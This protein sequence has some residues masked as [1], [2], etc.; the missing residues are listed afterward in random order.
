M[1]TCLHWIHMLKYTVIFYI[2]TMIGTVGRDIK[3]FSE[4]GM[5]GAGA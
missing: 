3:G 4:S 1:S 2:E 5:V